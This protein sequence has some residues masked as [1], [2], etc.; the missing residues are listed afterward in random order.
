MSLDLTPQLGG[1]LD[2]QTFDISNAETITA[3]SFV[4]NLTGLVYGVD[5][6]NF[7]S[8]GS[9]NAYDFGELIVQ[10]DNIIEWIISETDVDFGTF[11]NPT[12]KIVDLGT[13]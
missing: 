6:R 1:D 5:V 11:T 12:P 4:G 3:N 7:A 9:E 8:Y 2:V 10:V 13:F